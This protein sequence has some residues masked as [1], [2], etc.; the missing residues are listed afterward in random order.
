LALGGLV[1]L[2][3]GDAIVEWYLDTF[4]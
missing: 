3:F 1:G 4:V 2:F